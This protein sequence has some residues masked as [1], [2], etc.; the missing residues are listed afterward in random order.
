MVDTVS[1]ARSM[2][3]D[4]K[5]FFDSWNFLGGVGVIVI[6]IISF[7]IGG[8]TPQSVLV[9]VT[10]LYAYIAFNQMRETRWNRQPENILAVRPHFCRTGNTDSYDFGLKNFGDSPAL[11]LRVKAILRN[12]SD[13]EGTLTV[14][15]KDRHLHLDENEFLSL[16]AGVSEQQSFG[17]LTNA[18][19][20]IFENYE[21]KSI[22][23]YYTFESNSGVQYPRD[24]NAPGEMEMNEVIE[25]SES[26]R[27]VELAEIHE[28]CT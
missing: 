25:K 23:L 3:G 21:Q 10:A 11:N 17:D 14:S 2:Y 18:D 8:F 15:A 5:R 20:S 24:W 7:A 16:T 26:P 22:E 12:G 19:D 4:A 1:H 13:N 27:T 9:S 6:G 28:K